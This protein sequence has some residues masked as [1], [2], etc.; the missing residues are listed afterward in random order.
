V[1]SNVKTICRREGNASLKVR[2]A[3]EEEKWLCEEERKRARYSRIFEQGSKEHLPTQITHCSDRK[4]KKISTYKK[5]SGE[6]NRGMCAYY[7]V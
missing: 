7:F 4:D 3:K 2:L 5:K 6:G 1:I